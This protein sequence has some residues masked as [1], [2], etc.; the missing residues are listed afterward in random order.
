M[1]RSRKLI[2]RVGLAIVLC[3]A[4]IFAVFE[5]P[6]TRIK[7]VEPRTPFIAPVNENA[8][9]LDD[10]PYVMP[11]RTAPEQGLRDVKQITQALKKYGIVATGFVVGQQL[12]DKSTPALQ[13]FA[14]AGHVIG[15]HS[16]SHPDYGKLTKRAFRRETRRTD[17]AIAPWLGKDRFYRF[18]FLKEGLT[19]AAKNDAAQVLTALGYRN[20]PPTIDNDEWRFNRDYVDAIERGDIG[21]AENIAAAYIVHMQ[22]RTAHFQALANQAMGRDVKHI[23]LLHMNRINADHLSELL[24]WYAASGWTFITVSE[25]MT[26]PLYSK[27]DIY[28]GPKGLSQIERIM[29]HKSEQL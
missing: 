26:D 16:W 15:N 27:P 21:A 7:S 13:A 9:T 14:D 28:V 20:V 24:D 2:G 3:G 6:D 10:L 17:R 11:S 8:I 22:D 23:L 5:W 12:N 18:P 19:E 1:R 25:A 4:G 29:G